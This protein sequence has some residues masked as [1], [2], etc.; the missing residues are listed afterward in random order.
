MTRSAADKSTSNF[1]YLSGSALTCVFSVSSS[2]L[3]KLMAGSTCICMYKP[4][5]KLT[6]ATFV[7][8]AESSVCKQMLSTSAMEAKRTESGAV[9]GMDG[10]AA[11]I[12]SKHAV[13]CAAAS[14]ASTEAEPIA[15]SSRP[16]IAGG[17]KRCCSASLVHHSLRERARL[18]LNNTAPLPPRNCFICS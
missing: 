14:A 3:I 11:N 9:L 13:A 16:A 5:L 12:C 17:N 18:A 15:V 1:L 10:C 2:F 7:G 8:E 4:Q 6:S